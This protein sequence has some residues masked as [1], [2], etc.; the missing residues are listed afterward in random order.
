MALW[1]C[2]TEQ[3]S[4]GQTKEERQKRPSGERPSS[5]QQRWVEAAPGQEDSAEEARES[6]Q[7]E[8]LEA[9]SAASRRQ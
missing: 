9:A 6:S 7:A 2:R 1:V 4:L 5:S 3:G 8:R